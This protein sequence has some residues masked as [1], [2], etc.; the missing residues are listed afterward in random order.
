MTSSRLRGGSRISAR[1]HNSG[2]TTSCR[3]FFL[4]SGQGLHPREKRCG[5]KFEHPPFN[6][7]LVPKCQEKTFRR[8]CKSQKSLKEICIDIEYHPSFGTGIG[9]E[10]L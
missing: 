3:G 4:L 10:K 8:P 7:P 5:H 9:F 2:K 1:A 6:T